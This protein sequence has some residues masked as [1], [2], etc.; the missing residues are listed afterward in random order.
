M[1]DKST[2]E[3]KACIVYYGIGCY[4]LSARMNAVSKS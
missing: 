3:C 4:S 2:V 1:I